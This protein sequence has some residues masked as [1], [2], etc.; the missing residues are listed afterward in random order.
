MIKKYL[1]LEFENEKDLKEFN[2]INSHWYYAKANATMF[3]NNNILF[4][5]K[6]FFKNCEKKELI[7]NINEIEL[8]EL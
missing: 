6:R 3:A 2:R 7:D 8:K 1:K 5:K 4:L